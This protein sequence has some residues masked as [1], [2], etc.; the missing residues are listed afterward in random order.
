MAPEGE[1]KAEELARGQA[2]MKGNTLVYRFCAYGFLKNLQFFEPYLWVVLVNWGISLGRIGLL[3]SIQKIV[4]YIFELPSGLLADR[5][6]MRKELALCFVFYIVSFGFYYIGQLHFVFLVL[7]SFCY[8]MGEAMRSGTH[9]AMVV[10]WLEQHDLMRCK[11]FLYGK[12]R[13]WSLIG[14]GVSAMFSIAVMMLVQSHEADIFLWSVI[15]Y[16]ADLL[17]VLSY[18]ANLDGGVQ[19]QMKEKKEEKERPSA[20]PGVGRGDA[21]APSPEQP[22]GEILMALGIDRHAENFASE[23]ILTPGD[24][25]ILSPE[26]CR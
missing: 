22:L 24:L 8:G 13:S 23:H 11:S 25:R 12:T 1:S 5:W 18:P 3:I 26:D 21:E 20:P 6:G 4:C 16:I 2:L 7:A 15:P 19:H 10:L 9:K 17:V 14:S